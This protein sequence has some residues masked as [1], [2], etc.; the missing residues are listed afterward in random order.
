[1]HVLNMS[2]ADGALPEAEFVRVVG[3]PPDVIIPYDRGIAAAASLG[4]IAAQKSSA[5]NCG[6]RP[7]CCETCRRGHGEKPRSILQRILG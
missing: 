1:M 4:A 6:F 5:L 2:G 3:H 7:V